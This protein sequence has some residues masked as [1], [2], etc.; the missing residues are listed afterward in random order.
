M[1][2]DAQSATIAMQEQNAK[3]TKQHENELRQITSMDELLSTWKSIPGK[4][5]SALAEL[6]DELK[7]KLNAKFLKDNDKEK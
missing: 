4:Y 1:D 6:K 3:A 5:K 7:A 2:D